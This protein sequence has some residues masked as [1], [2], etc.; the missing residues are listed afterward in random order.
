[1]LILLSLLTILIQGY[2]EKFKLSFF[3]RLGGAGFGLATATGLLIGMIGISYAF[4]GRSAFAQQI[5]KSN[6]G[7]V[8]HEIVRKLDPLLSEQLVRL[9]QQ[10]SPSD[11]PDDSKGN[12]LEPDKDK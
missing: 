2:V 10:P 9:Y 1:M 6:V 7:K 11:A 12:E 5:R 8:C 3:N 4:F